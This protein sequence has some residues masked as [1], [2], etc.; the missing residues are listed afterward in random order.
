MA[1]SKQAILAI[2]LLEHVEGRDSIITWPAMRS[3]RYPSMPV[4]D[5][6]PGGSDCPLEL[7]KYC[8]ELGKSAETPTIQ[9][10]AGPAPTQ[11]ASFVL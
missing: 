2:F 9:T 1:L 4:Q 11:V 5:S 6:A 7:S 3:W 10:P 8:T